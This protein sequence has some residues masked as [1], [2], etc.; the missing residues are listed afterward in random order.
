VGPTLL[1]PRS[2][3]CL[4]FQDVRP[5]RPLR[6]ALSS[7]IDLSVGSMLPHV[8]RNLQPPYLQR[9]VPIN[10]LDARFHRRSTHPG[11]ECGR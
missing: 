2:L 3:R 5:L 8:V 1:D 9:T 11:L 10:P 6:M 4:W 7:S